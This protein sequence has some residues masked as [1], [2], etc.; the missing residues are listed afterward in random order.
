[1]T[2]SQPLAATIPNDVKQDLLLRIKEIVQRESDS[3]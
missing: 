3:L 2:V 1:M